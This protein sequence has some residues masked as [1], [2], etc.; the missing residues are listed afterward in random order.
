M[1]QSLFSGQTTTIYSGKFNHANSPLLTSWYSWQSVQAGQKRVK[2]QSLQ[3]LPCVHAWVHAIKTENKR[4]RCL[5]PTST[6]FFS[7][8]FPRVEV[9]AQGISKLK[10]MS[11]TYGW[12]NV[13]LAQSRQAHRGSSFG[14]RL[15]QLYRPGTGVLID[16]WQRYQ[17]G[18]KVDR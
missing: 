18:R 12:R 4:G 3:Q 6:L 5:W 17:G 10:E 11:G 8:I 9:P 16:W 14:R 2:R 13:K 7:R 1:Q 15:R